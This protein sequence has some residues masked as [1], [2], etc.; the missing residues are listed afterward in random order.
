MT[1]LGDIAFTVRTKGASFDVALNTPPYVVEETRFLVDRRRESLERANE[2]AT[3]EARFELLF[4]END[5]AKGDL[6]D[7]LLGAAER[8]EKLTS[9]VVYEPVT[10]RVPVTAPTHLTEAR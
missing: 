8:L 1:D 7:P 10:A 3:H 9:D 4:D 6:F 2:I 5:M